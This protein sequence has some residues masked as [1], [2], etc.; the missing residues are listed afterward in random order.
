MSI[1]KMAIKRITISI[2]D[3][4]LKRI[5]VVQAQLIT[6]TEKSISFSSVVTQLIKESLEERQKAYTRFYV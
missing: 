2:D 5:K 4:L 1:D 6:T 3:E